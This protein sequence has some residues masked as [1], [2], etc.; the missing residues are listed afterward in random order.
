MED[1]SI[2]SNAFFF[3]L[4][5]RERERPYNSVF[6]RFKVQLFRYITAAV[7]ETLNAHLPRPISI[8]STR[9]SLNTKQSTCVIPNTVLDE[10]R[11]F[12]FY[13]FIF[14]KYYDGRYRQLYKCQDVLH[15]KTFPRRFEFQLNYYYCFIGD[16]KNEYTVNDL[17]YLW[18]L[19]VMT[20][21]KLAYLLVKQTY[22]NI[23]YSQR[24]A[25][26]IWYKKTWCRVK[27]LKLFFSFYSVSSGRVTEMPG[28][29]ITRATKKFQFFRNRRSKCLKIVTN[30]YEKL[31][32]LYRCYFWFSSVQTCSPRQ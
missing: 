17:R 21:Y 12:V 28:W 30:M 11:F 8:G 4:P 7:R 13:L 14:L 20:R 18:Y 9:T 10:L 22:K 15:G 1:C 26:K 3:P 23:L 2:Y 31:R 25:D 5:F 24:L 6:P 16:F 29:K 32:F 27:F 19:T